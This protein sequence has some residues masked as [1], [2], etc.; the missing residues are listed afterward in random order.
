MRPG[1]IITRIGNTPVKTVDELKQALLDQK[2][3]FQIEGIY[4]DSKEI[5]Y[6]GIND[7]KK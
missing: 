6:F 4:P 3:N 5:Y 1:F 2:G 7:F